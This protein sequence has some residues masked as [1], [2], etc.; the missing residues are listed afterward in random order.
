M[1]NDIRNMVIGTIMRSDMAKQVLSDQILNEVV[2][3]LQGSEMYQIEATVVDSQ[4]RLSSLLW[5]LPQ[6]IADVSQ[7]GEIGL[8]EA[9]PFRQEL[10]KLYIFLTRSPLYAAT[11][12]QV[13]AC[14]LTCEDGLGEASTFKRIV[15]DVPFKKIFTNIRD[16]AN[17]V[18]LV[19]LS[20]NFKIEDTS[21]CAPLHEICQNIFK[22]TQKILQPG[23][24]FPDLVMQLMEKY[25]VQHAT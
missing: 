20:E 7:S 23:N 16:E 8:L 5:S 25:Q 12:W 4:E 11:P 22:A 17:L 10:Y 3:Y 9:Q 15:L 2:P 24:R 14:A 1:V 6:G 21:A 19:G 13:V 18:N